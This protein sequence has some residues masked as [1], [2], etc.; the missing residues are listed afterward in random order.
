LWISAANQCPALRNSLPASYNSYLQPVFT[1]SKRKQERYTMKRLIAIT[2]MLALSAGMLMAQDGATLFTKCA[3]CHGANGQGKIGPAI[4][5]T[6]VTNVLTNG[7][8]KSPHA[9]RYAGLTDEQIKTVADYV[10]NLK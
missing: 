1:L 10:K 2:A 9:A 5:G 4:K 7:G 8:K 6:D 3:M